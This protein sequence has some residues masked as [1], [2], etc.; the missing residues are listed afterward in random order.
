MDGTLYIPVMQSAQLIEPGEIKACTQRRAFADVAQGSVRCLVH[1]Q[2]PE[3]PAVMRRA[4]QARSMIAT[5]GYVRTYDVWSAYKTLSD[6]AKQRGLEA[7][8][9]T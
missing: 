7:E 5:R 6:D 1:R 9:R 3:E 2:L 8:T 4:R